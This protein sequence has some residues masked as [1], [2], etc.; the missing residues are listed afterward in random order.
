LYL[1]TPVN[2]EAVSRTGFASQV[3]GPV[4]IEKTITDGQGIA[5]HLE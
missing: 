2:K 1:G 4:T 5:F 3:G